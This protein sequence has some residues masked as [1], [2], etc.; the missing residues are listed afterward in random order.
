M[1]TM[2]LRR[3]L[4]LERHPDNELSLTQMAVLGTLHGAGELTVGELAER[5]RVRPPSMTRTVGCLESGGYVVRRG[6]AADGRRVLVALTDLGRTALLADRRRR[7]AWLARQ[8]AD[9]TPQERDVLRRAAP[10]LDRLALE[11]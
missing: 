4:V 11:D 10:M 2:R 8:L 1:A 9:L 6:S 7:D 3:R 5:E